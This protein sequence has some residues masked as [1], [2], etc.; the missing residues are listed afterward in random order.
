MPSARYKANGDNLGFAARGGN[1]RRNNRT[2]QEA[3]GRGR[4]GAR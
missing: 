3:F 1:L 2:S 4:T